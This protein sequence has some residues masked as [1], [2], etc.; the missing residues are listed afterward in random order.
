MNPSLINQCQS[1]LAAH[2]VPG[3]QESVRGKKIA[4]TIS[5]EAGAGAMS[6]GALVL[7]YLKSKGAG[8]PD[9]PWAVFDR[10]LVKRVLTDHRLPEHFEKYMEE[11]SRDKVNDLVEDVLGLH[12]PTTTLVKH[13][14]ETILRLALAGNVILVGR[15]SNL[16]TAHLKHVFHVRLVAPVEMRIRRVEEYYGLDHAAAVE[17]V[18]KSDKARARYIRSNFK[19]QAENPLQFHLTINTGH[20]AY[21]EA[22]RIIGEAVLNMRDA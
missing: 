18:R 1:Y 17:F 11:D 12:P 13:T 3:K 2:A 9:S 15:G 14:N 8:N 5:R 19:A 20:I 10:E 21:P 22:A 6:V 4:V 7:E 16:V